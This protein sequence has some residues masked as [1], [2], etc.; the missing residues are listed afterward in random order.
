[1]STP[2]WA[3]QQQQQ[4]LPDK[5]E[6]KAIAGQAAGGGTVETGGQQ[7]KGAKEGLARGFLDKGKGGS[8]RTRRWGGAAKKDKA[9]RVHRNTFPSVAKEWAAALLREC[10][11]EKQGVDLMGRDSLLLG[12]LLITLGTFVEAAAPAPVSMQLAAAVLELLSSAPVGAHAQPYV[13]RAAIVTASQVMMALSPARVAGALVGGSQGDSADAL[14]VDRLQAVR[15]WAE[16]V[17][18]KDV[19]PQCR[20]LAKGCGN[21]Q[22]DLAARA[23]LTLKEQGSE[24][25]G[26]VGVGNQ[27]RAS[28]D[29]RTARRSLE[30]IAGKTSS[31]EAWHVCI[32]PYLQSTT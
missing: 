1:M 6:P 18:E 7:G 11:V 23:L 9:Q 27:L 19:D 21:L 24:A 4:L 20:M 32:K 30:S 15:A 2:L 10:D 12:R 8:G 3:Q 22:A 29:Q 16:E 13:R 14:L 28:R 17:A 5:A 31:Q 26:T 25:S